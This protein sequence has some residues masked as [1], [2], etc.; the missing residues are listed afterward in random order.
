[1][2]RI[3]PR[4]PSYRLACI[5]TIWPD[6][7]AAKE[8]SAEDILWQTHTQVTSA[9][10]EAIARLQG[11]SNAVLR[12]KLE[13]VYSTYLKTA[14]YFYKG[15]LQRVCARYDMKDLRRIVR[16]ADLQEMPVPDADKVNPAA[17]HLDDIVKG[18]VH[19][20][21][22][23]LGDLSRYRTLMRSKDRKWDG[24]LSYYFLANEL[25]PESGYG[26]HQCGVIYLET[27]N[28]L[29]V[30][31]HLYRALA[32]DMPH[33]NA[34]R[35]LKHEFSGLRK[36]ES[37][38]IEH[39]LVNWFVQLHAFYFQGKEFS[40]RKALEGE[41]DHR[42]AVSMKTGTGLGSDKDLLKLILINISAYVAA[43]EKI[44]GRKNPMSPHSPGG[45]ADWP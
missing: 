2:V 40:K 17:A 11:H 37:T 31:Y 33:P 30:V 21:L 10:R 36:P 39:A 23:Y 7:R 20:M 25:I 41:V 38:G 18:S 9:Y 13:R 1:M 14:Q 19:K 4:A 24:P 32:C 12:R 27:E 22:I 43:Q 16:Q 34:A 26:H 6:I 44:R 15:Y 28:H 42:L 45:F 8:K 5:E 3:N 35:N 29:E